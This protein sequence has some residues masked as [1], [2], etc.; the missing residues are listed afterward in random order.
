MKIE[1]DFCISIE[2]AKYRM[3]TQQIIE[4]TNGWGGY[5]CRIEELFDPKNKFIFNE[6]MT[7]KMDGVLM[8]EKDMFKQPEIFVNHSDFLG[9]ELW[10]QEKD[11]NFTIVAGEENEIA[12]HKMCSYKPI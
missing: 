10:K 3:K 11:K 12:I 1:T 4:D 7:I 6:K 8:V 9:L 5:C 2:S